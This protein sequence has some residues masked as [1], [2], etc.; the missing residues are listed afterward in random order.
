MVELLQEV[1]KFVD[2]T[3][4]TETPQQHLL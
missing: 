1:R 3:K 2:D 4:I